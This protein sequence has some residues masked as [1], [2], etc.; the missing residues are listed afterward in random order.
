[1]FPIL[2]TLLLQLLLLVLP[3]QPYYSTEVWNLWGRR[4]M[5]WLV[6]TLGTA[7]AG[8]LPGSVEAKE[9]RAGPDMLHQTG[10]DGAQPVHTYCCM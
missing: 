1:M 9:C 2:L 6:H 10:V 3:V 8:V 4:G 7:G 5:G